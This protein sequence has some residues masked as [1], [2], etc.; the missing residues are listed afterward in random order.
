MCHTGFSF[1]RKGGNDGDD[2]G[3]GENSFPDH[4]NSGAVV[5][6]ISFSPCHDQL[7][8]SNDSTFV[9][10]DSETQRLRCPQWENQSSVESYEGGAQS[11]E[12]AHFIVS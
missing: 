4:L 5:L 12:S 3:G 8:R 11:S 6:I 2:G 1:S 7:D 10:K 9:K